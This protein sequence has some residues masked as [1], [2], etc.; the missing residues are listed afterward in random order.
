VIYS[1]SYNILK[2][3]HFVAMGLNNVDLVIDILYLTG[4]YGFINTKSNRIHKTQILAI[5]K[6]LVRVCAPLYDTFKDKHT[7]L[8]L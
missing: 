1:K 6:F 8:F 5:L 4:V 7:P 3:T 2:R